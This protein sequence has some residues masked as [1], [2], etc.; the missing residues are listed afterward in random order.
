MLITPQQWRLID[1]N[2]PTFYN[3]SGTVVTLVQE[4]AREAIEITAMPGHV[5]QVNCDQAFITRIDGLGALEQY[6][7]VPDHLRLMQIQDHYFDP[8]GLLECLRHEMQEV[9]ISPVN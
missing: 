3:D 1:L 5:L 7:L 9:V 8:E 4:N 2:L 6:I